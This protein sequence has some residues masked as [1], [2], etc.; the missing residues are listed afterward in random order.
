MDVHLLW[1]FVG[2]PED[3]VEVNLIF[4][5]SGILYLASYLNEHTLTPF[6]KH[7]YFIGFILTFIVKLR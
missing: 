4:S 2:I 5:S 3:P 7:T 1:N 6:L